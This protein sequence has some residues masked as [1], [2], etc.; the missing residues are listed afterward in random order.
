MLLLTLRGTSTIYYGDEI[1]MEQA[2][3]A[4]QDVRDPFERNVPGFGLGRD[5]CRTPMPWDGTVQAGFS[6]IKPWLPHSGLFREDN[7]AAQRRDPNSIYRLYRRLIEL[8][9]ER[10]ALTLGAYRPVAAT[11]DLLVYLRELSNERLAIALNLGSEHAEARFASGE[12]MGRVLI[13]ST[14]NRDGESV[15]GSIGLSPNEGAIIDLL[16]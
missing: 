6:N 9:R 8:R 13:S 11:G 5:G 12:L 1:G 16:I 2:V 15:R 10:K 3:I 14:R 7:V 4:P